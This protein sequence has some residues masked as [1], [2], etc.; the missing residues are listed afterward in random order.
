MPPAMTDAFL[1]HVHDLLAGLGTV[2]SRAMFGGRG[3]Y[4]DGAIVGIVFDQMLYLKTDATTRARFA[5][6][7]SVPFVYRKQQDAVAT[8]Y[9]SVP[10]A[11][12]DS[13][14]AMQPWA[15]LARDAARRK[16][17]GRRTRRSR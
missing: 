3:V 2:T 8:S 6:A 11:A 1:A 15:H 16:V 17:A 10:E 13:P 14:Q 4:L 9:W 12:L 5:S 7:G